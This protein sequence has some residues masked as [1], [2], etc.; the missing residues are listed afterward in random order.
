MEAIGMIGF[1]SWN[2]HI[3]PP[4]GRI[5]L[6]SGLVDFVGFKA[7]QSLQYAATSFQ[8]LNLVQRNLKLELFEQAPR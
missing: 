6:G 7:H 8:Q 5:R 2:R 3:H 1:Q 4:F